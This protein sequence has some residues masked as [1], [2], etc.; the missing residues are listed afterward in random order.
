MSSLRF[1]TRAIQPVSSWDRRRLKT[2]RPHAR[3]DSP[4]AQSLLCAALWRARGSRDWLCP[5]AVSSISV[6]LWAGPAARQHRRPGWAARGG[7]RAFQSLV[8][9]SR[10]GRGHPSAGTRWGRG[11]H[12]H[13]WHAGAAS[14]RGRPLTEDTDASPNKHM[15]R[16]PTAS[17]APPLPTAAERQRWARISNPLTL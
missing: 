12:G 16:R 6:A 7:A 1:P 5:W 3:P 13:A 2:D 11:G 8:R 9:R 10:D 15:S 4:G 14:L 17:A